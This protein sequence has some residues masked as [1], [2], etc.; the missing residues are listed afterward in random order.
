[1]V[2]GGFGVEV[3]HFNVR[4]LAAIYPSAA[5]L[6]RPQIRYDGIVRGS[7]VRVTITVCVR[8]GVFELIGRTGSAQGHVARFHVRHREC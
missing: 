7:G 1:M 8:F 6:V 5:V 2:V 3:C 4:L